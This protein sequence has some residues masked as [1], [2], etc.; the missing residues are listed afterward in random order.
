VHRSY[1]SINV[2][3]EI[4]VDVGPDKVVVGG[5]NHKDGGI[6]STNFC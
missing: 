1:G 5:A 4:S 3:T 2:T 6:K